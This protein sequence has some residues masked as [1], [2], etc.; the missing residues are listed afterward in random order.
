MTMTKRINWTTDTEQARR[1][2]T[3]GLAVAAIRRLKAAG[4]KGTPVVGTIATGCY[5]VYS[6]GGSWLA[7]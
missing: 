6:T 5:V 1:Y 4:W 7:K 3:V 2:A